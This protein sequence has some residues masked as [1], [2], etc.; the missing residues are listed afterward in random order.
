MKLDYFFLAD[1]SRQA[2]GLVEDLKKFKYS[3][4]C[5]KLD[6]GFSELAFSI[7]GRTD[8]IATI[9]DWAD[10]MRKLGLKHNPD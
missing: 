5:L 7:S 8:E 3:V 9:A 4:E 6:D 10:Q 1:E 2:A